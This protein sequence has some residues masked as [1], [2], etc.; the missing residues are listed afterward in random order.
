VKRGEISRMLADRIRALV[1]DLLP[2]GH[3][4]GSEWRAGSLAGEAG[5]SLGVHLAGQK[6]GVWCDFATGEKGDALELVRATLEVDLTG[7]MTWARRWLGIEDEDAALP[8]WS[9]SVPK[10]PELENLNR[11]RYSWR[12][13]RPIAGTLAETYLTARKLHFDDPE[14]RVLRF[15]R[16]RAR[17][18][19]VTER[20]EYHPALLCALS[21]AES[22]DQCGLVN[23]YLQP[24]GR[25]RLR[26]KKGKTCTGRPGSAVIMLSEFGEP[27]SGLVLC[28]GVETGIAIFQAELRPIWACGPAGTLATFPVLEGIE[29]LTIAADADKPG[30]R[31]AETLAARWSSH[32]R[33]VVI[34]APSVG[35][36]ADGR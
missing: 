8:A 6:A 13:A 20:I 30:R 16:S 29:A 25:D 19:P 22:G 18:H 3:R 31:A 2:N 9:T 36:W 35:D 21:D 15:A 32:G 26:D 34:V 10:P 14:G 23:I 12:G 24:H 11:W 33:E 1:S 17:K 27:V 5:T 28:E 7:A 4:E